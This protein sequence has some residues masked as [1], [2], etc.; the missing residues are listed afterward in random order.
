MFYKKTV[1]FWGTVLNLITYKT[2]QL[3]KYSNI[4]L[5]PL[6]VNRDFPLFYTGFFLFLSLNILKKGK[7]AS[8]KKQLLTSCQKLT[9]QLI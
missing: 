6:T 7:A 8:E 1:P 9:P 3:N 2:P 4:V 5:N